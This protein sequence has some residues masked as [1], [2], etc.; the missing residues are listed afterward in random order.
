MMHPTVK[1]LRRAH[2]LRNLALER[3]AYWEAERDNL[4]RQLFTEG[5]PGPRISQA[6]DGKITRQ[7]LQ[8]IAHRSR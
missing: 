1:A 8:Q 6:L 7:R 3:A 4:I 5:F 2:R